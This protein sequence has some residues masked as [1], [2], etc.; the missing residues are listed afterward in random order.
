MKFQLG[1]TETAFIN[2]SLIFGNS[3]NPTKT[4]D[5]HRLISSK[6]NSNAIQFGEGS[7][8]RAEQQFSGDAFGTTTD[9]NNTVVFKKGATYDHRGGT[10][11]FGVNPPNAVTTFEKGS[12]YI[13]AA[14][15][16]A[17]GPQI[18]GRTYG[19]LEY[20]RASTGITGGGES[21]AIGNL[22]LVVLDD[23][24]FTTGNVRLNVANISIQGNIS[25]AG[26]TLVNPNGASIITLNG[27]A[28]QS[29]VSTATTPVPVLFGNNVTLAIDNATGVT[30]QT[31]VQVAKAL[32]LTNGVVKTTV[33][34][35][36]LL[37]GATTAANDKSF[38]SGPLT[39]VVAASGNTSLT[40]PLGFGTAFRPLTLS[41][42]H[43]DEAE[44][45]YTAEQI[46]GKPTARLFS[47]EI[48][49]VSAVRYFNVSSNDATSNLLSGSIQLSYGTDD[50][51]DNIEKLRIVKSS[52]DN[53]S[54]ENIGGTGSTIPTGSITSTIPFTSLGPFALASTELSSTAGNNPLP[55]ELISFS[56]ERRAQGVL[57]RWATASE[58]SNAGFEVERSPDGRLFETVGKVKG[59]GQKTQRQAYSILD[60]A[61]FSS[62]I[63]YYRLRQM[64]FDGTATYSNIVVVRGEIK[65]ELFP[66]PA[67]NLLTFRLPYNGV[68]KYRIL[69]STGQTLQN[70]QSTSGSTTLDI[71]GLPAGFYYLEIATAEGRMVRKFIKQ[72]D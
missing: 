36:T 35:L 58:K 62:P 47:G 39:R 67:H 38:V 63:S 19:Y 60:T 52:P 11:P 37:A 61:P 33:G 18:S 44:V 41:V 45:R 10:T 56:A 15:S 16:S 70:G 28:A 29:I 48:N 55:V 14:S 65:E 40:F 46:K 42:N 49:K 64:D 2:G 12:R 1:V 7:L 25:M 17:A 34:T 30:L 13:Y 22:P 3:G 4:S 24:I 8:F 21:V 72:V 71:S 27:S 5:P 20:N 54:W 26:G 32:I 31:P 66:N 50:Q 43:N 68:A 9:Y 69:A 51:V 23:I 57:L 59:Q 53:Q 6:K